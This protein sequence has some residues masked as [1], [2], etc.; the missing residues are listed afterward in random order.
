[1]AGSP[2]RAW[3]HRQIPPPFGRTDRFTPTCVGTSYRWAADSRR[4]FGSP[5]RAWGHLLGGVELLLVARF[6][7]TC[8]GTSRSRRQS[9]PPVP[10]H[11][12]V[13]GDIASATEV[14]GS[15]PVHP[16]VRGDITVETL[17]AAN[18]TG[19][20]PRAWGHLQPDPVWKEPGRFTPTC[21]GTSW[22]DQTRFCDAPVHPHVRGDI[23]GG[24]DDISDLVG[25]PP[26]AWGHLDAASEVALLPRF[27]PTCVGTSLG[28]IPYSYTGNGSPPRAWG[29]LNTISQ[30]DGVS[31]FTPTCVGTS[32]GAGS[33]RRP[34]R[35]TPTCVGTSSESIEKDCPPGGSPPRAW[36]HLGH[37]NRVAVLIRFT[38][39]CVGTSCSTWLSA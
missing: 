25:S 22:L 28:F 6:T 26:R 12:H 16:H 9:R 13:R 8:V 21:V 30:W 10:V 33:A 14:G 39:T 4:I 35:F 3:G 5:P 7:P 18:A 20:P 24:G 37:D 11:P 34:S 36:G 32:A 17:A 29:H 2:P 19:S 15:G 31:R 23:D 1:M 38:P 27:T